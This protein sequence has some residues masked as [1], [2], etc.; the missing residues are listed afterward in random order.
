MCSLN[1][2]WPWCYKTTLGTP[3]KDLERKNMLHK[4]KCSD[5][6]GQQ[7][8]LWPRASLYRRE[9]GLKTQPMTFQVWRKKKGG[10]NGRDSICI[11]WEPWASGPGQRWGSGGA[12]RDLI[13]SRPG[14]YDFEQATHLPRPELNSHQ[15]NKVRPKNIQVFLTSTDSRTFYIIYLDYRRHQGE[16]K[17]M[18]WTKEQMLRAQVSKSIKEESH[19]RTGEFNS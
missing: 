10:Y 5:D 14:L 18:T 15:M 6:N 13:P 9:E 19:F 1:S 2:R 7:S 8:N 4:W 11:C 12:C 17:A 16:A 3:M